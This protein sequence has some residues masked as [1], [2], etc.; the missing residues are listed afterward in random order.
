MGPNLR[1]GELHTVLNLVLGAHAFFMDP[2]AHAAY[3]R[4][5]MVDYVLVVKGVRVGSMVNT[6]EHGVDPAAFASVPFLHLVHSDPDVDVY[7]V[8]LKPSGTPPN[9]AHF[10]GLECRR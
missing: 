5:E 4:R 8:T 2:G 7:S 9:P 6:L 1:P 3:L 10:S